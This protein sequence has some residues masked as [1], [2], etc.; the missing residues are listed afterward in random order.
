MYNKVKKCLAQ[1]GYDFVECEFM[2]LNIG[3]R[4]SNGFWLNKSYNK[5]AYIEISN[6]GDIDIWDYKNGKHDYTIRKQEVYVM[7]FQ[8]AW[9]LNN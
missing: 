7:M 1:M 8:L 3:I 9:T 5:E 6:N 2:E 4:L